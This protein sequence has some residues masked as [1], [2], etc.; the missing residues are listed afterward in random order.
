MPLFYSQIG[1]TNEDYVKRKKEKELAQEIK[2]KK[3][4]SNKSIPHIAAHHLG[5]GN[6]KSS[7][8]DKFHAGSIGRNNNLVNN[9]FTYTNNQNRKFQNSYRISEEDERLSK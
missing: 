5:N 4:T 2:N 6:G 8:N 7:Y 9:N 1:L 3:V